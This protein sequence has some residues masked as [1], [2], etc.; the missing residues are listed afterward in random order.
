MEFIKA[1]IIFLSFLSNGVLSNSVGISQL[2]V[3]R[4]RKIAGNVKKSLDKKA[5]L[6]S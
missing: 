4:S 1:I 5:S 2:Y 3:E 6:K